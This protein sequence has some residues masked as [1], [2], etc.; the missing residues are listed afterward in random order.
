[1]ALKLPENNYIASY[2]ERQIL[3]SIMVLLRLA[4]DGADAAPVPTLRNGADG[5]LPETAQTQR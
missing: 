1:M 2:L 5:V 3:I 4:D